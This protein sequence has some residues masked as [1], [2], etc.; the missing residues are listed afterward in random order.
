MARYVVTGGAGFIGSHLVDA[1]L[2]SG[3]SV[4]VIDNLSSGCR[5]QLDPRAELLQADIADQAALQ[6]AMQDA[7]GCFHLAAI[8]PRARVSGARTAQRSPL[9]G[10]VSVLE[11][12]RRCGN[13][14]VVFASG[15]AIY[16]EQR[17]QPIAETCIPAPRTGDGADKLGAELQARSAFQTHGL[18]SM[19]FRL[20]SVYGPRQVPGMPDHGVVATL[21]RQLAAG[22]P[23]ILHGDGSQTRDFIY[24]GD[25]V[26]FLLR[27]M[28]RIQTAPQATVVN[29][30]T[31]RATSVRELARMLGH[32]I[33]ITP[34]IV[35][36]PPRR[37]DIRALIGNPLF[38]ECVLGLRARVVLEDGV[39]WTFGAHAA[40]PRAA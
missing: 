19:G 1:L 34:E 20:F 32:A 8:T 37:L 26:R 11:A 17:D 23:V 6:N 29:A 14:P 30:C 25:V 7:I 40:L 21:A 15:A 28:T 36:G 4:R 31:G 35:A 27:G 9:G 10:M 33:G 3:H 16:G 5:K 18:P 24:V 39:A 12:A 13:V 22:A 2:A 38:S